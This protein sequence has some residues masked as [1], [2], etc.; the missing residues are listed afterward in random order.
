MYVCMYVCV[1]VC[2]YIYG[3]VCVYGWVR[4]R[5]CA[6]TLELVQWNR[7]GRNAFSEAKSGPAFEPQRIPGRFNAFIYPKPIF[8]KLTCVMGFD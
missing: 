4:V 7:K 2:V 3:W 6:L 1:C 5:V 8:R